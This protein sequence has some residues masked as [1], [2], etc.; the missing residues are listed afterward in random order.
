MRYN[1]KELNFSLTLPEGWHY[2][3]EKAY[4][5]QRV[6]I[7]YESAQRAIFALLKIINGVQKNDICV[8][9]HD[10][11]F[12]TPKKYEEGVAIDK[13]RIE[14]S[15]G[16]ILKCESMEVNQRKDYCVLF[17]RGGMKTLCWYAL[18]GLHL[19]RGEIQVLKEG[20]DKVLRDMFLS[21]NI[22]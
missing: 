7:G 18:V 1:N 3:D 12:K 14:E 5:A 21:L 16:T 13:R 8:Y 4:I 9:K 20:D 10:G 6:M 19:I 11:K 22:I 2:I 17:A 15:N